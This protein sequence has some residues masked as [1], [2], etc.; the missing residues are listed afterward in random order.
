M[1]TPQFPKYVLGKNDA[2][3]PSAAWFDVA[4]QPTWEGT[5]DRAQ[6]IVSADA[7]DDAD[8]RPDGTIYIQTAA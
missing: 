8:G 2:A 1:T 4:T 6:I 7:P 5:S 3:D